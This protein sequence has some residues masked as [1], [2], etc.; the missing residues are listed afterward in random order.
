MDP[1][2][3]YRASGPNITS[4]IHL[5][6][7]LRHFSKASDWLTANIIPAFKKGNKSPPANYRPIPLTV[8][9]CRV[10]E[11]IIFHCIINHL[12]T[13]NIINPNQHGFRPGFSCNTQLMFIVDDSLKAMDSRCPIDLVLLDFSKAF[14]TVAHK[15]L[16]LKL[17]IQSNIHKWITTWLTSRTQRVLV[18]GWTSNTKKFCL[19]S[20]KG[21][22]L[23]P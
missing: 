9:C 6:T 11:Y 13:H 20:P 14:N 22:Y 8:I 4:D 15:K 23:D 7:K 16:L 17:G 18:E 3:L 21:L 5:V 1:Q 19:V 12:N 10:M 2:N